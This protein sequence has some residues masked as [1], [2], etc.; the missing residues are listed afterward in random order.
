MSPAA[1]YSS[2]QSRSSHPGLA[3]VDM[4]IVTILVLM[5]ILLIPHLRCGSE[6][7]GRVRVH[8]SQFY[9][10]QISKS[11]TTVPNPS[12]PRASSRWWPMSLGE[13]ENVDHRLSR[14]FRLDPHPALPALSM[15]SVR[16]G[17][18]LN[19][20]LARAPLPLFSFFCSLP[21]PLPSP[22]HR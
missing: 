2:Y 10:V 19:L 22:R 11:Q 21:A 6:V 1:N 3:C 14:R 20:S 16:S 8:G 12:R 13:Y 17:L 4:D 18:N 5:L 9:G 15:R 7:V